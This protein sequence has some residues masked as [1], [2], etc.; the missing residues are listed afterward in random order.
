[1]VP[2]ARNFRSTPAL[3]KAN[4]EIFKQ[5]DGAP[6]FSGDIAYETPA[7]PGRP[8]MR[9]TD[10]SGREVPPVVL[11]KLVWSEGGATIREVRETLCSR[12]S[13][14]VADLVGDEGPALFLGEAVVNCLL[15]NFLQY[16]MNSFWLPAFLCR[17]SGLQ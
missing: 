4:N 10:R 17:S 1:M 9:L 14:E 5:D 16:A 8:E 15:K 7:Q 11:F 2:L 12:M 13:S 3:L 6:F